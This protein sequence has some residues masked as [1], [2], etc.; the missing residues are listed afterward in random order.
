MNN[1][2][3]I[4]NI[5]IVAHVD[6]GKTTLSEQLLYKAGAIRN[7]GRVDYGTAHTDSMTIER[8]RGISVKSAEGSFH[9]KGIEIHLIDTPGHIDF[10]GEV[11]RSLR[12][13]DGAIVVISAVDGVQPQTEIYFNALKQLQIP[14]LIFINKLD[15][16]GV[17]INK[18]LLDIKLILTKD[19]IS[20]QKVFIQDE[21]IELESNLDLIEFVSE[22]DDYILDLYLNDRQVNQYELTNSLKSIIKNSQ[23]YPVFYG[24]ALKDI[25]IEPL[26]DGIIKLLP[27][28]IGDDDDELSAVIY[29]IGR[30]KTFG[31]VAYVRIY[32]GSIKNR[33]DIYNYTKDQHEKIAQ[34]KK[35]NGVKLV[36]I[37]EAQSGEYA[38]IAGLVNSSIGDILGNPVKVPQAAS[39]AKPL[40]TLQV[41]P[42][43]EN[44]LMQVVEAFKELEEE[45]SLLMIQWIREKQEIHIQIMGMIQIEV[46]QSILKERFNLEVSFGSPSVIYKETISGVG[47]GFDAYT[48]PKPCWA[49]IKFKMEPLPRGSGLVYE[50]IVNVNQIKINYQREVERRVPEALIQGLYG[51]EVIDVKITLMDGEYHYMHT[52]PGDFIVAT[53]MAIMDGLRSIGTTLLEPI[54]KFRISTPEDCSG[55]IIGDIVN[56]RGEFETPTIRNG[57]FTIEGKLPVSTSLDF[58]VRLAML[59]RGKGTMTCTF[60]GYKPCRLED[61]AIRDRVGINPLDRAKYILSI[62]NAL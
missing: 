36:D 11:E 33:D 12:V 50:S 10:A 39:I 27:E 35:L 43:V 28:P 44:E 34:I 2:K 4:R 18:L 55:K 46:L 8:E 23:A 31:N 49:I 3:A 59:S 54:L 58:P 32:S 6:A 9:Y 57:I 45:D 1:K 52:H 24:S 16:I 62:R 30:D 15:R 20:M 25:G 5:G 61:G 48:M 22:R 29:K 37:G 26:M 40:L 47:Y 51:W 60:F 42:K 41:H 7:L 13:L 19:L 21:L 14:T 56:M 38:C 53:P 17:D